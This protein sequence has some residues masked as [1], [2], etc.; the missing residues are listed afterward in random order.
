MFGSSLLGQ[1]PQSIL[2]LVL[3]KHEYCHAHLSLDS[4]HELLC[5]G[6]KTFCG[7]VMRP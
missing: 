3:Y 1:R 7:P 5:K 2:V 4:I 6:R